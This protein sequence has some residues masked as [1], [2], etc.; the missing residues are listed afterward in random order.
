MKYKYTGKDERVFPSLGIRVK[1]NQEF[2]APDN[3]NAT[4]V[5][6]VSAKEAT[7]HKEEQPIAPIAPVES[8]PSAASDITVGDE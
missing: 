5:S 7:K 1:P 4:D 6:R 8:E 3:F 2:D